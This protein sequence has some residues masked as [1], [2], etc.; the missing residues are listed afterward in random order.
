MSL[1]S[2]NIQSEGHEAWR[3]I[4]HST[5]RSVLY[6]QL[7]SRGAAIAGSAALPSQPVRL[8][9]EFAITCPRT[10]YRRL[11]GRLICTR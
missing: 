9:V 2:D 8:S 10:I 11:S 1:P 7:T 4:Q 3:F 5:P 6:T